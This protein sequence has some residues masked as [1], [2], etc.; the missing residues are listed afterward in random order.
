MVALALRRKPFRLAAALSGWVPAW[1]AEK[2]SGAVFGACAVTLI[3]SLLLGGGTRGGFLSDAIL[4]LIAIPALIVTLWSLFDLP[5][6]TMAK[7]SR[8]TWAVAS[9]FMIAV[10]PLVQ[11]VPLPP[12][13]WTVLPG[14]EG[15]LAILDLSR[16]QPPRMPISVSPSAT[17]LS[18]LALLP[19]IS[20][21]LGVIQLNYRDRR[22]LSLLVIAG[23]LLSAFVGLLQVAQGAGS[24]LRFFTITNGREAVGFFANRNHFAALTYVVLLFAAVWAIDLGFK[25]GSLADTRNFKVARI[26][27]LTFAL[28]ALIVLIATEATT[29]SRAGVILTIVA[30]AGVFALV[31]ADRRN[32]S[33]VTPGKLLLGA[34]TVAIILV[35]QF[36]LYRILGRFTSDP[37]ADA[38]IPFAQNTIRAAMAFM[39]FGS[40]IGT[41]VPVYGMFERPTDTMAD[42][43]ANHAH[44]DFLE[45]WLETGAMGIALFGIFMV[46]LGFRIS[47]VWR[48]TLAGAGE[49]DRL[50]AQ[51]AALAIVL[52]IAHSS[53]DYP[54]R[55]GAMMA[56]LALS[57]A[58]LVE[59][60]GGQEGQMRVPAEGS[61]PKEPRRAREPR[62]RWEDLPEPSFDDQASASRFDPSTQGRGLSSPRGQPG[63]SWGKNVNWPKEWQ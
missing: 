16:E 52:L 14:R 44:N 11:L 25:T 57:C 7:K 21:F 36:S 1:I 5:G 27:G 12:S 32:A 60:L 15:I 30:L 29:R 3:A 20:I 40:G 17:W 9:C 28:L 48:K 39:P 2:S 4:E 59:P 33:A 46:W 18:F 19:P 53:V 35:V 45:L 38:R 51:A 23:G 61:P 22:Q 54:L 8:V 41:F 58:L 34:L 26:V 63:H 50:L 62:S 10:L 47:K 42:I 31:F 13:V 43:Y 24:P 56:I 49:F 6:R 55:T 37:L